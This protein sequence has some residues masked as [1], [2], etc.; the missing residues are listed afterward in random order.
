MEKNL[1]FWLAIHQAYP[2]Q[3]AMAKEIGINVGTLSRLMHG[4]RKPTPEHRRKLAKALGEKKVRELF[5][6][7]A[8]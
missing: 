3:E 2:S 8:T 1:D 7:D 4:W 6:K 5:G